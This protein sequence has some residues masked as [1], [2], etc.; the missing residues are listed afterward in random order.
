MNSNT[1]LRLLRC[2][3]RRS[4]LTDEAK[5]LLQ[6]ALLAAI[7]AQRGDMTR[8]EN[9]RWLVGVL[10]NRALHEAPV[11]P[12]AGGSAKAPICSGTPQRRQP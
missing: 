7:E 8:S 10:R 1:Y 4:R 12:H 5:D 2:A 9:R 6:S 11:P 3:R